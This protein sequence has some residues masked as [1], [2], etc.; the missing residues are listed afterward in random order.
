VDCGR[1][2]EVKMIRGTDTTRVHYLHGVSVGRFD[3][4]VLFVIGKSALVRRLKLRLLGV[5][6]VSVYL[7]EISY[8]SLVAA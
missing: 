5:C 6:E 3:S 7:L 8:R 2:W 4:Q 1:K